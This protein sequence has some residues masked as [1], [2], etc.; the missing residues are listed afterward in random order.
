MMR[1]SFVFAL[2][3]SFSMTMIEGTAA[4]APQAP[5]ESASATPRVAKVVAKSDVVHGETRTDNYFWLR[6]KPNPDV[7]AYL[8][9]ENAYADAVMKPTEPLQQALYKEL[10][11]HIKETDLTVPFRQGDYFYYSRTEA[12]KQYPI[13]CRK[14]GSVDAPEQVILDI[15]A[16][17]AGQPFMALGVFEVSDDGNLLAYSTDNT[18]FR[19][20]V[21]H[22]KD[23]SSGELLPERIEKTGSV[24]WAADNSTVFY[25][26]ED[27]AKRQYRLYRH[28]LRSSADDLI[29]EE[30]DERFNVGVARTRSK[31]FLLLQAA[32]HTTSEWRYLAADHPGDEWKI[33][34]AR[35]QDHEYDVDH[36]GSDFYIRTNDKGR[37]FRLV[38]TPVDDPSEKNWKEV[39]PYRPNVMLADMDF[40]A[41]YYVLNER[42]DDLQHLLVNDFRNG[43]TQRVQFPEPTYAIFPAQ[44]REYAA[45]TFRYNYQSLVTPNSVFDYEMAKHQSKLLKRVEVPGYDQSQYRSERLWATAKDGVKVP[46]SIA[47]RKDFKRDGSH[48]MFLNGYGSYGFSYP[49]T[50]NSNALALMDR[51]FSIAIAHIRGGGEMG[52]PWH[53]QG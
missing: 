34:A 6:D 32:S 27:A 26:V 36:H 18:G 24:A 22:V 19:Q 10:L 13:W 25:T 44:N 49:V 28:K 16:L 37:N 31:A 35:R 46:I 2:L 23:L 52:K 29:Y 43:K 53:D 7:A 30:K 8:E 9:A 3:L 12:G 21:L 50:F 11:G 1:E 4:A 45:T 33:V 39:V 47:Y 15:N 42:E 38:S 5:A 40:F 51:G 41:N 48:P 14:K 20:Y 17:A